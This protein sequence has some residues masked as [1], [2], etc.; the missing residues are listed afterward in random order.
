DAEVGNLY[1]RSIFGQQEILRLDVT[2]NHAA[3]V[4]VRETGANLFKVSQR[5]IQ[6]QCF[7]PAEPGEIAAA[8]I[9]QHQIVKGSLVEIDSRPV[10]QAA[11]DV[12][13]PPAV[14]RNR[15]VLKILNQRALEVG[16]LVPLQQD[17]E[18]LDNDVTKSFVGGGPVA[19]H[20]NL[21]VAAPAETVFD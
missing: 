3:L 20:I 5:P 6:R 4:G 2:M 15:F 18:G 7:R 8:Q 12:R 14:Q 9:F 17:I 11:D 13:M 19:G 1:R 16:V 10:T 21:G